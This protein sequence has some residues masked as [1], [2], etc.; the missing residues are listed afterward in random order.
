MAPL[1]PLLQCVLLLLLEPIDG[2]ECCHWH[3][4]HYV[5]HD[6]DGCIGK[7]DAA[8]QCA[9]ANGHS[10]CELLQES[11]GTRSVTQATP[12]VLRGAAAATAAD[13]TPPLSSGARR[14]I[15]PQPSLATQS[16]RSTTF[17]SS[18]CVLRTWR[19]VAEMRQ[20]SAR[21]CD[22]DL[23]RNGSLTPSSPR[24]RTSFRHS[25]ASR[26][27]LSPLQEE[28]GLDVQSVLAPGMRK[29]REGASG[30]SAQQSGSLPHAT[31]TPPISKCVIDFAVPCAVQELLP[32]TAVAC[33]LCSAH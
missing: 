21:L 30:Q 23:D 26:D 12:T 7:A 15:S 3:V 20:Q 6:F 16:P 17:G 31:P 11:S 27:P 2:N 25:R 33:C 8:H 28:S 4:L 18:P 24:R 22:L 13:V 29:A 32:Q 5:R 9:G 10:W 1:A 14:S 19:S